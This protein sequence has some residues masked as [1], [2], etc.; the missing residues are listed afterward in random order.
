MNKKSGKFSWLLICLVAVLSALMIAGCS[1][2]TPTTS[3]E[4]PDETL[5]D[6][7]NTDDEDDD[8][9]APAPPKVD[10]Y[11]VVGEFSGSG[12][13]DT[14]TFTINTEDFWR[15][16]I[17]R[18]GAD[19]PLTASLYVAGESPESSPHHGQVVLNGNGPQT[20]NFAETGDFIW[21][22]ETG[23]QPWKIVVEDLEYVYAE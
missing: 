21:R 14:G 11:L 23:D 15:V 12:N 22:I 8:E 2:A 16:T 1:N 9:D 18:E 5:S 6:E 3:T 20:W 17:S 7:A 19:S 13:G 4:L 10:E